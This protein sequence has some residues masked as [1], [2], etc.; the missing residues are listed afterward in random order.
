MFYLHL[1]A[2][3]EK[4]LLLRHAHAN[5]MHYLAHNCAYIHVKYI[6]SSNN[7]IINSV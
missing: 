5:T 3:F 6:N 2:L 1:S 4:D 7:L